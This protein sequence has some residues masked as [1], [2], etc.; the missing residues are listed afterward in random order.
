[1]TQVAVDGQI[2]NYRE[3]GDGI[4]LKDDNPPLLV[5]HGW[6]RS[7]DEW[8][9]MAKD[10]GRK[11]YVVDLPGFG[12]SS[13]PKVKNIFE[14]SQLV[15]GFCAYMNL[16]KVILVGHSLGGRVGIVL[17]AEQIDLVEKLILVDPAGVKPSSLKRSALGTLAKLFAW[18]PRTWRQQIVKPMMDVDYRNS[19][20][21]RGLYRAV[22]KDDLRKYLPR[23]KC[24][25]WVIW[26]EKDPILPL[27]L[28]DIY[29]KLLP[30][31]TA[32]II[33][34]AGHDPHLSHYLV[35]KRILEEAI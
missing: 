7:G 11:A 22:V 26:G 10:L 19:P 8:I 13:L 28:T 30:Y 6:G 32:R 21:L 14:Y 5:L 2:W 3:I 29:K 16:N 17:A 4:M 24:K 34:G 27:S 1:M 18:M 25:T 33:W 20:S 9:Q 15:R 12:G 23:I 35:L 31:P